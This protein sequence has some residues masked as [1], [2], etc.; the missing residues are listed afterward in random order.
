M[1]GL[2]SRERADTRMSRMAQ[3]RRI[4]MG[5]DAELGTGD[6]WVRPAA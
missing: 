2:W 4:V 6:D 1:N 5:V 3:V